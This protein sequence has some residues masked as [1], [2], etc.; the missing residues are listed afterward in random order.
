L[1]SSRFNNGRHVYIP[2]GKNDK[3]SVK[4]RVTKLLKIKNEKVQGKLI[5][6]AQLSHKDRAMRYA[7]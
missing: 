6:D 7:R 3:S 2:K 1:N 4:L 5:Q